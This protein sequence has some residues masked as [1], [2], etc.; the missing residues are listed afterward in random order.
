MSY[1]RFKNY[2][3]LFMYKFFVV[4]FKITNYSLSPSIIN[5]L[6]HI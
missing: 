3:L 6:V 4:T 1:F 2:N 5:F